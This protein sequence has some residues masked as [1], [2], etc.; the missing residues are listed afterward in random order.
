MAKPEVDMHM[1]SSIS[2]GFDD[3]EIIPWRAKKAGLKGICLT[4]HDCHLGLPE[5]MAAA[6]RCGID[7][8]AGIEISTKYKGVDVHILGYGIDFSEDRFF[9]DRLEKYWKMSQERSGKALEQYIES[10]LLPQTTSME[11]IKATMGN[12]GPWVSLMHIRAYRAKLLGLPYHALIGDICR[13]GVA[14]V[15]WDHSTFM[16]PEEGIDFIEKGGGLPVLAHPDEFMRRTDSTAKEAEIAL[17]E[18]L[19]MF[20]WRK[21]KGME[22]YHPSHT[23]ERRKYYRELARKRGFIITAGS[24][25]HGKFKPYPMGMEGVTHRDFLDFKRLCEA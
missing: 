19:D 20:Q 2:D 16:T 7:A 1:H 12:R 3:P 15:R 4:D 9:N 18:V 6:S 5:F 23:P 24:D 14:Y 17:F 8:I 11:K 25:N 21:L 13:G 22:V 10:G